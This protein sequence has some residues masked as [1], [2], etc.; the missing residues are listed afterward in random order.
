MCCCMVDVY[1]LGV[2]NALGPRAIRAEDLGALVSRC[3]GAYPEPP[4]AVPFPLAQSLVL[5][6]VDYA[7]ALGFPPHPDF[8]LVRPSLGEW[9]GPSPITFGENGK[10]LFIQGPQDDPNVVISTLE[11]AVGD[12]NFHFIYALQ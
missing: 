5:G 3:F 11:R 4:I 9:T 8:R 1:C 6:A 10:P 7:R 2:K 12:G